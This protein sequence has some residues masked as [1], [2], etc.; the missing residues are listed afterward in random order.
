M[1]GSLLSA[2]FVLCI[3]VASV[4]YFLMRND[5]AGWK[6][7]HLTP[8]VILAPI[9]FLLQ[10][11]LSDSDQSREVQRTGGRRMFV[12]GVGCGI[13]TLIVAAVMPQVPAAVI[14][15]VI[16]WG[17]LFYTVFSTMKKR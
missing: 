10:R 6:A 7:G 8:L 11:S 1:A 12:G 13:V 17:T 14:M 4:G 3:Y 5:V 16:A 15:F 2:A 9:L